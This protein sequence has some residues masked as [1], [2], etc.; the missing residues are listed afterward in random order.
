MAETGKP[1]HSQEPKRKMTKAE[2]SERFK[3]TARRL[4]ADETGE[5]FKRAVE[6]VLPP[7]RT[8]VPARPSVKRSSS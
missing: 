8:A 6:A 5:A 1:R 3:E 4:G 7:R 2:Q